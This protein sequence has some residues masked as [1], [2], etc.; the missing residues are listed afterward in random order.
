MAKVEPIINQAP[1]ELDV[2]EFYK[3]D[4]VKI[5]KETVGSGGGGG[6]STSFAVAFHYTGECHDEAE[7]PLTEQRFYFDVVEEETETILSEF[8]SSVYFDDLMHQLQLLIR[9]D[10]EGFKMAVYNVTEDGDQYTVQ[11]TRTGGETTIA[12]WIRHLCEYTSI[13]LNEADIEVQEKL[14]E[15]YNICPQL[16][17]VSTTSDGV[18]MYR[19]QNDYRTENNKLYYS[20]LLFGTLVELEV[21]DSSGTY[22]INSTH[23]E[24]TPAN[25]N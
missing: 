18:Q 17:K 8:P 4:I 11:F 15:I 14:G 16:L 10:M 25:N 5:I 22:S 19:L 6:G 3:K 13:N 21:I 2:P 1:K 12:G 24:L 23:Y 20:C 7:Q 9:V